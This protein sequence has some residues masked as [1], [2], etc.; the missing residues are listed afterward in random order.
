MLHAT[1]IGIGDLCSRIMHWERVVIAI[2]VLA[3]GGTLVSVTCIPSDST[4]YLF[5]ILHL[6]EVLS[7]L[8]VELPSETGTR[9]R[10][11]VQDPVCAPCRVFVFH[12]LSWIEGV[13]Q[14]ISICR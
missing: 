9:L 1:M 12:T 5:C 4:A 11:S 7:T 6:L 8:R 14:F 13:A 2:R 3:E 10:R